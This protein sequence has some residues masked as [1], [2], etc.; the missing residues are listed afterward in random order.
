MFDINNSFDRLELLNSDFEK[1]VKDP[2]NI[3]LAEKVCSDAWHLGD[4]I[5]KE[6]KAN[7]SSLTLESFRIEIYND[8]TNLKILH[9]IANTIKHKELKNPKVQIV[10]T[11]M[12]SGTFDYT[13]SD[14]FDKSHLDIHLE[15]GEKYDLLDLLEEAIEYWQKR[16][17]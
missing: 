9:D 4:W 6:L 2:L 14:E 1:L 16:I 5:F 3:S 17:I 15:N 11:E 8:V 13:F 7:D 10:K 12:H